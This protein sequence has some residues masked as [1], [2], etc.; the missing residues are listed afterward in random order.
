[1]DWEVELIS[2][3]LFV[4][5]S[6]QEQLSSYCQ[7]MTN[8]AD[9][10]FSDEESIT[11]YLFG[12]IEGCRTI[13]A[14]HRY[15]KKHLMHWFPHLP[16]YKAFD[17][18]M[19][20]LHDIFVPFVHLLCD[21]LLR[22]QHAE[23]LTGLTDSMPIIMAQRGRRFRA[24]VSP[25]IATKNGYCA[26]KKL[27]YYG[28]KL[29]VVANRRKGSLPIPAYL[30][31]TDAGMHDRK[32][33]EQILPALPEAMLQCYADKAYQVKS[34]AIHQERHV[35]L[36]TP[37]K[38]EKGQNFLDA[39][40]QWLSTAISQVRQ[41]IESLFNWV[42]EK[43]GIQIA[44]KVRSYQGLMVHVFGKLAAALFLMRQQVNLIA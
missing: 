1:M 9:L 12:V 29:H 44:S 2:L 23:Q 36:L 31:L 3:Y 25:E 6:Y 5:K 30:G 43:T 41:P 17:H 42:N 15:A 11:L 16:G 8:Y 24:K 7:R 4:C 20:Q 10:R 19:N 28:V 38:K 18:R 37:V 14:I 34:E 33:F 21:E 35:T 13:K 26:T 32:A 40:D 39:A 27:H 22:T